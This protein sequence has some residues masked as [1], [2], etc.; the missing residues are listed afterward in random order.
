MPGRWLLKTEPSAYSFADLEKEGRTLWNGIKNPTALLHLRQV[1][2][3]DQALVYHTGGER[4][5]LGIAKVVKGAHPD[6]QA[7]DP[8]LVAIELAPLRRLRFPV[9]LQRLKDDPRF[10]GFDLLRIGRLSVMPVPEPMWTAIL[11]LGRAAK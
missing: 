4:A 2:R 10:R 3:G 9:G 5:V 7:G 1:R 8:R 11:E 6:P